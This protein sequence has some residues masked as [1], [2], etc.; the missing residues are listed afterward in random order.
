MSAR[1]HFVYEAYDA[2]GLLL[3]VGCTGKPRDRFK[4]HMHG[5]G[6][7]RGWFNPFLDQWRVSGPYAKKTALRIERERI[8]RH[9][10]IWNGNV[11]GNRHGR[12]ELINAYLRFHG[13]RFVDSGR[14]VP[15]LIA[16]VSA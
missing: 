10:P 5:A 9:R 12:R 8:E 14:G 3:Y 6:D 11:P 2:D 13:V 1:T 4:A 7:A 16:E 15:D